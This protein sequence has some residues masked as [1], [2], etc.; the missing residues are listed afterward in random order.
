[1]LP[2]YLG[3]LGYIGIFDRSVWTHPHA[4]LTAGAGIRVADM[5]MRMPGPIHFYENSFRADCHAFPAALALVRGKPDVFRF[6][7]KK[8]ME[9]I[10][11]LS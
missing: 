3:R 8:K 2:G 6:T 10:H 1:V 7:Q 9:Y 5:H 11:N 4:F